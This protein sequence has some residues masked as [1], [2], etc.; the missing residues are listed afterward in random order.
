MKQARNY[1][2]DKKYQ[3]V[4]IHEQSAR[5]ANSDMQYVVRTYRWKNEKGKQTALKVR[6]IVLL[7]ELDTDSVI[8]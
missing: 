1:P 2:W 7:K 8:E 3:N 4:T 6:I 5:L